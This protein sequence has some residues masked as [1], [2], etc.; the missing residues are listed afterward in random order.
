M[1][2]DPEIREPVVETNALVPARPPRLGRMAG[3]LQ[4]VTGLVARRPPALPPGL[5]QRLDLLESR[6][7][8]HA[9]ETAKRLEESEGRVLHR[10]QQ[11]FEALE[12]ELEASLHKTL[13]REVEEQTG[14]LRR[15]LVAALLLALG[16]LAVAGF[17]LAQV[18]MRGAA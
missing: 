2:P 15:W 7:A 4:R 9:E 14:A 10:M 8:A 11:R 13:L 1:S 5:P 18:L 17:T 6:L 3:W 16:A 12:A